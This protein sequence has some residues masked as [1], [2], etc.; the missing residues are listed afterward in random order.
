MLRQPTRATPY[1]CHALGNEYAQATRVVAIAA[2]VVVGCAQ[3]ANTGSGWSGVGSAGQ[4]VR[5]WATWAGGDNWWSWFKFN[6]HDVHPSRVPTTPTRT[7]PA[8]QGM[9]A[10]FQGMIKSMSLL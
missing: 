5:W 2:W 3:A 1:P 7:Y 9:P 10:G 6:R 8:P 4:G